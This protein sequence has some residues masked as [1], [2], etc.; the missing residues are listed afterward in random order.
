MTFK[1]LPV[2]MG[3]VA[4]AV[5]STVALAGMFACAKVTPVVDV[6]LP[7]ATTP[8]GAASMA[9]IPVHVTYV[10]RSLRPS[11]D[12]LFPPR[13]SINAP[14]CTAV[15]GLLCHQ[16]VYR[17]DSLALK[18]TGDKLQIETKLQYR[19]QL[20]MLGSA[21]LASCGYQPEQ[22]RRAT[23]TMSTAL[24]WRRD[25]R[26][27][28]RESQ[29]Q[30]TLLDQCLV[31][32]LGMNA[33]RALKDLLNRQLGD[34]AQQ[35]DT[36]IPRV[37]D[38]KPLA[39]SLWRSFLEPTP[40]DTLGTLWL[41]L[42]PEAVRVSP[43][44][45]NGINITTDLVLYARPRVIS[46]AKP[47]SRRRALPELSLGD[48]PKQFS[49]PVSVELPF[50]DVARRASAL[51]A[52]ETATGSIRIDSVQ[53]HGTGDSVRIDLDV[54]RGMRGRLTLMSRLR[55]DAVARELRLDDLEWTLDS[56]GILSGLKAT[57][58]A[59]LVGRAIRRATLG[60]RIPLGAQL[61]SVRSEMMH[62]LN[63]P[64]APGAVMGTSVASLQI[65]QVT[66]N[67]TAFVVRA[68]L[69]GTSGVWIQ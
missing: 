44:V 1:R 35:A 55:W 28:A 60:G 62:K 2:D 52:A 32:M 59:P 66:S 15:G 29:L 65:E 68:R 10:L 51:L 6:P 12:S 11:L 45:G 27:G 67:A 19:A 47:A 26:I 9:V 4:A 41:L 63:G 38:F 25:W 21:R 39:D 5:L 46:G 30:A 7:V 69:I 17:R 8:A 43:L 36:T 3:R 57:L 16:Y 14:Q 34:F 49:V 40:L 64:V 42:E 56:Q 24:Y 61:D 53:V 58:G 48:A 22:M 18:A 23:L 13:D 33:T 20:G 37:A 50:A 31:T 54:S